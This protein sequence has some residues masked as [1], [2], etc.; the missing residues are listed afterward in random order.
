MSSPV[1]PSEMVSVYRRLGLRSSVFAERFR[2]LQENVSNCEKIK[3]SNSC[4]RCRRTK[5]KPCKLHACPRCLRRILGPLRRVVRSWFL[6]HKHLN[7]QRIVLRVPFSVPSKDLA[8]AV[9]KLKLAVKKLLR[10]E[11][12]WP[13]PLRG[14]LA[15]IHVDVIPPQPDSKSSRFQFSIFLV[16]DCGGVEQTALAS[17]WKDLLGNAGI[18]RRAPRSVLVEIDDVGGRRKKVL[19]WVV[20]TSSAL[21]RCMP[22]SPFS[23]SSYLEILPQLC[24]VVTGRV[25]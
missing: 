8:N 16:A 11:K 4:S 3:H 19:R 13:R 12:P 21:L 9:T 14:Y 2:Q 18:R 7:L 5:P 22:K 15:R 6:K 20:P 17:R 25:S 24:K 1:S 23:A 10:G